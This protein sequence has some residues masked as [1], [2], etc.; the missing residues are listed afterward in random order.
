MN[1]IVCHVPQYPSHLFVL[2]ARSIAT[3]LY[4]HGNDAM[5]HHAFPSTTRYVHKYEGSCDYLG[6]DQTLFFPLFSLR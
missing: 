2:R 5:A 4:P 6:K 3:T 1:I